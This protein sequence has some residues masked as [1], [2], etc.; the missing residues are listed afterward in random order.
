M[1]RSPSR[2]LLLWYEDSIVFQVFRV[3]FGY[4]RQT[5]R[6]WGW[7]GSFVDGMSGLSRQNETDFDLVIVGF[8]GW[9]RNEELSEK[10]FFIFPLIWN[11]KFFRA[12]LYNITSM[13]SY[14]FTREVF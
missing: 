2:N 9:S 1:R 8:L 7:E 3:T 10:C 5:K 12:I 13:T 6:W 14:L 11:E 4:S